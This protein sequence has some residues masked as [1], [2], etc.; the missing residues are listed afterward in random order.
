MYVFYNNIFLFYNRQL[1]EICRKTS[2][3]SIYFFFSEMICGQ[4]IKS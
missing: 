4:Y 2:I 3:I 1:S